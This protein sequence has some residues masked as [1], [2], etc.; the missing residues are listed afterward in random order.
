MLGVRTIVVVDGGGRIEN[1]IGGSRELMAEV[2][3]CAHISN[4]SHVLYPYPQ[5]ADDR[6]YD[7][8]PPP[9]RTRRFMHP[10]VDLPYDYRPFFRGG[11]WGSD[12]SSRSCSLALI[13]PRAR[14]RRRRSS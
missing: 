9:T 2:E 3:G 14:H 10:A 8:C 11:G 13:W 7:T 4:L 5:A 6:W 1:L 12:G